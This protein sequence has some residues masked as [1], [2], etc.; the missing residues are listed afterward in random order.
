MEEGFDG[1]AGEVGGGFGEVGMEG[2]IE[3]SGGGFFGFGERVGGLEG[4]LAMK[5]ERCCGG[6]DAMLLEV[7]H[8]AG[9][10]G[11][12]EHRILVVGVAGVGGVFDWA[13]GID[14]G[15]A[16]VVMGGEAASFEDAG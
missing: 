15:K 7:M 12:G 6:G 3:D 14:R 2:E 8:Q 4:G 5:G 10:I 13:K 11:G 9:G 1:V 16:G